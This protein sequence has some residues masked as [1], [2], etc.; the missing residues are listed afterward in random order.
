MI[1]ILVYYSSIFNLG[2]I[3]WFAG[4]Y[5]S[6]WGIICFTQVIISALFHIHIDLALWGLDLVIIFLTLHFGFF[7]GFTGRMLLFVFS[8]SVCIIWNPFEM[9]L[10]PYIYI[11]IFMGGWVCGVYAFEAYRR[12]VFL[13]K[14]CNLDSCDIFHYENMRNNRDEKCCFKW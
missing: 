4:L 5:L 3:L 11:Y 9:W 2:F 10:H 14:L 12:T 8:L 1:K 13:D 7:F 6:S